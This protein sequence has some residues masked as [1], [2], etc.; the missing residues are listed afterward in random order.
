MKCAVL[1]F[2]Q[3]GNTEEV[4]KAIQ[5]GIQETGSDCDLL[6]LRDADP[7]RLYGY[8]LIGIG[9]PA[10]GVEPANVSKFIE[11][12]RFVGGKH[13]FIFCTHGTHPE[14]FFPSIYPKVR[15]RE[16]V[17]IGM[18]NWYG[19]CYL[20]HMPEPYPTAGHPDEVDLQ[21]A[22]QF[23]K[24]MVERSRAVSGGDTSGIPAPPLPPPPPPADLPVGPNA[25][26]EE[27]ER[28]VVERFS[29]MLRF[30]KEK[31]RYPKCRLCMENC[32]VLGI[33][34]SM[35]P[36]VLAEPCLMCEFCARVCPTGALDI[37][38]WVAA[39]AAETGTIFERFLMSAID[40]AETEGKFRRLLPKE[41]LKLD[42]YGYMVHTKHPSW[43]VGKGPR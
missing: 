18:A 8:D 1:Y 38:E 27:G 14:N 11:D 19:N 4:A 43:I 35:D 3:T 32:P 26:R 42:T 29:E 33:D 20:L 36:P 2:T 28:D 30:H 22:V 5:K 37:D 9:S 7:T 12:M 23:G 15:D 10:F 41:E 25:H 6:R 34:L 31:C 13:A 24:D 40:Q 39:V 21:E 16:L 17:V